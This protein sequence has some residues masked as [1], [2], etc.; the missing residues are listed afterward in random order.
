M[1]RRAFAVFVAFIVLAAA[2]CRD[3][4][5]GPKPIFDTG[6]SDSDTTT[7]EFDIMG[8]WEAT[9]AEGWRMVPDGQGGFVEIPGSRRDLVA[10]GG[11]VTLVLGPNDQ[12][13]N[14][15]HGTYT[16]TVAMP[17]AAPG[18]DTG[19]WFSQP[20]WLERNNGQGQIDFYPARFD[21]NFDY[22]DVPAFLGTLSEDKNTLKLWDSGMTFL[23]YDF[24]W[25]P[26]DTCLSFEFI[27]RQ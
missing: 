5:T 20:A 12:A 15:A 21:H 2:G 26:N 13:N 25:D 17:G 27:R 19:F 6:E 16:I 23:P 11:T 22:G 3:S 14:H 1:S 4:L 9:K 18:V 8:T 24:G 7:L 10:E